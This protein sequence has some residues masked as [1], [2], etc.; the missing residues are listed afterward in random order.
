MRLSSGSYS[1]ES[2]TISA[3]SASVNS[4][5]PWSIKCWRSET[6]SPFNAWAAARVAGRCLISKTCLSFIWRIVE[7]R[8]SA[9]L[10]CR[11]P[12][13]TGP[14][15]SSDW[16]WRCS[17]CVRSC[18]H[19]DIYNAITNRNTIFFIFDMFWLKLFCK[20][21]LSCVNCSVFIFDGNQE[22]T[23]VEVWHVEGRCLIG[24]IH[25]ICKTGSV[26]G[27]CN[28]CLIAILW[29]VE[30]DSVSIRRKYRIN[31]Q[32][33]AAGSFNSHFLLQING[34]DFRPLSLC[35]RLN[36][37]TSSDAAQHK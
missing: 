27:D 1:K 3:S 29:R 28:E 5:R 30:R 12:D 10:K 2:A 15:V 4:R 36:A 16:G 34:R 21:E 33:G 31:R 24:E 13:L 25:H 35:I 9:E 8:S 11:T 32:Y 17:F 6:N 37:S 20:F 14:V 19:D 23:A 7:D 22:N 26:A 18:V